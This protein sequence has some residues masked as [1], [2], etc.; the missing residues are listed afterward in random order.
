MSGPLH[1]VYRNWFS[2]HPDS[3][4]ARWY[5]I[6]LGCGAEGNINEEGSID[7]EDGGD[8]CKLAATKAAV[9]DEA[10]KHDGPRGRQKA[11]GMN[12]DAPLEI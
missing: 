3:R 8:K 9:A 6:I 2:V 4:V 12:V 7:L 1:G 10:G 11:G 5:A